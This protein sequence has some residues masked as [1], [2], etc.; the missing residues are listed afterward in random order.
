MAVKDSR[1]KIQILK[2]NVV[3]LCLSISKSWDW[4]GGGT[5]SPYMVGSRLT[6]RLAPSYTLEGDTYSGAILF[7]KARN[8][9]Y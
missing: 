1:F 4:G 6:I 9:W 2:P 7:W 8:L 5:M 3:L